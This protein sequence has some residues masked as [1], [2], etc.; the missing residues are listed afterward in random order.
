[1]ENESQA[2]ESVAGNSCR[3]QI[4]MSLV[5]VIHTLQIIPPPTEP[6]ELKLGKQVPH[7][8]QGK[9]KKKNQKTF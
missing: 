7:P 8:D 9:E 1:M 6:H 2:E 4:S 3:D 5:T